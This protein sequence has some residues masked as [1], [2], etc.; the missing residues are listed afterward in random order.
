MFKRFLYIV[1]AAGIIATA[2]QVFFGFGWLRQ[3]MKPDAVRQKAYTIGVLRYIPQTSKVE[4][5]FYQGMKDLGYEENK[6][7]TYVIT[8]Y[9]ESPDKMQSLAQSLIDQGVDLI[10][11]VTSVAA[12]GAKK[13]TEASARTDIPIVFTH[14]NQP[15]KQGHIKSFRSSG[16]NL[17][18]VAINYEEVTEKK[19]EFLKKINPQIKKIGTLD[20]VHTDAA[21]QFILGALRAGAP[22]FGIQ[23][24]PYKIQNNVGSEATVEIA[25]IAQGIRA[26]DIDAFFYLAG[27]VSNPPENVQIIIDAAKRLMVPAVYLVETQVEQGGLMSYA[28]D[29]I[30]MGIQ[31]AV[32]VDKVLKGKLPTDIPVELPNK[33]S[34]IINAKTAE[35]A[36]IKIPPSL[37]QI[38]DRVIK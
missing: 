17:T 16:N 31:T 23:V 29:Q 35:E 15:D 1:I 37:L 34:L 10:V 2:I 4:D 5:G 8:Q 38:A 14:A 7:T 12:G 11:A 36:G 18:G 19:L 30:A 6:N 27:P 26:G 21:G 13:A 3:L 24:L 20:A 9:G 25:R 22:K 32:M 33:N 28:H